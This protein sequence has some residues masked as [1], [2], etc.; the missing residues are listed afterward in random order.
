MYVGQKPESWQWI[1]KKFFFFKCYSSY[2]NSEDYRIVNE[3]L[4]IIFQSKMISFVFFI[5]FKPFQNTFKSKSWEF[6][7]Y[8]KFQKSIILWKTQKQQHFSSG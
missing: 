4:C 7:S 1:V 3:H 2:I 6:S 8:L 5:L